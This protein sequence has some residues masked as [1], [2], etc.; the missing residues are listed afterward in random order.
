MV[1]LAAAVIARSVIEKPALALGLPRGR[2]RTPFFIALALLLTR[3][4]QG[5]DSYHW[6][7]TGSVALATLDLELREL[8]RTLKT[9]GT[10]IT[11]AIEVHRLGIEGTYVERRSSR[12]G[13]LDGSQH[14]LLLHLPHLRPHLEPGVVSVSVLDAYSMRPDGWEA[15][16]AWNAA[17]H[18]GQVWVGEL[19]NAAFER[20]CTANAIPLVRFD[21]PTIEALVH[22]DYA[23]CGRGPLSSHELCQRAW[24]PQRFVLRPVA[25]GEANE[26]IAELERHFASYHRKA[27]KL[28]IKGLEE[29]NVVRTARRLFYFLARSVT[30]LSVYESLALD[31]PKSFRPAK[32]L[33]RVREAQASEFHG[34]W[35][36]LLTEWSAVRHGL[37]TLYER[38]KV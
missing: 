17:D 11:D 29:P 37:S 6:R 16:F 1:D 32:A 24:Y 5:R 19:G 14:F 12:Q 20:F 31:T 2:T 34:N 35:K 27:S 4:S 7:S 30:P 15:A 21:W 3:L 10:T 33:K 23:R 38:V 8:A 22:S 25:D 28:R 18:R 9:S 26:L 13:K 36:K